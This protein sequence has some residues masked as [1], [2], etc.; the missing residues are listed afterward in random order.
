MKEL[1]RRTTTAITFARPTSSPAPSVKMIAMTH[2]SSILT[3][4]VATRIIDNPIIPATEISN[5]L[6]AM[7]KT[8]DKAIMAVIA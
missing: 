7:G 5:L 3:I 1:M 4:N 6:H 2:G 8:R